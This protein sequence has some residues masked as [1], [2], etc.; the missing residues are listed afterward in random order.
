MPAQNLTLLLSLSLDPQ[1]RG[2]RVFQS[3][4]ETSLYRQSTVLAPTT[5]NEESK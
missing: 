1:L 4:T 3:T 2:V 5:S